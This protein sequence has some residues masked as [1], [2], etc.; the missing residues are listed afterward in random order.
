M[1][2]AVTKSLQDQ[3]S[4]GNICLCHPQSRT[5]C[6]NRNAMVVMDACFVD[7]RIN[8][9]CLWFRYPPIY[10]RLLLNY[11]FDIENISF[12]FHFISFLLLLLI[13]TLRFLFLLIISLFSF[14]SVLLSVQYSYPVTLLHLLYSLFAYFHI[15]YKFLFHK[16]LISLYLSLLI[17]TL[18]SKSDVTVGCYYTLY[19]IQVC[20]CMIWMC[21]FIQ[22]IFVNVFVLWLPRLLWFLQRHYWLPSCRLKMI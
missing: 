7:T 20:H 13:A 14:V 2:T 15:C 22:R 5:V 3:T 12:F 16:F 21:L 1:C 11:I 6:S 9:H 19:T 10:I 18:F 17:L 8:G 4:T